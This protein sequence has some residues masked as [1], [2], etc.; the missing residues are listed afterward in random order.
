MVKKDADIEAADKSPLMTDDT[1]A[2]VK[3]E[4]REI[5]PPKEKETGGTSAS[6]HDMKEAAFW[7]TMLF[8]ASVTMTVGNKVRSSHHGHYIDTRATSWKVCG[9]V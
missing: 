5:L 4:S 6:P 8:L 1:L 3:N 2:N 7:L 9:H